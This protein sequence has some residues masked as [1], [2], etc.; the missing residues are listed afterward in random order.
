MKK[1]KFRASAITEKDYCSAPY[2]HRA[3]QASSILPPFGPATNHFTG[4]AQSSPFYSSLSAIDK[5]QDALSS[6]R[7]P[8]AFRRITSGGKVIPGGRLRRPPLANPR[9]QSIRTAPPNGPARRTVFRVP[10]GP[11]A[12]R[13]VALPKTDHP[14]PAE[15][16]PPGDELLP[17]N[18]FLDGVPGE[19]CRSRTSSVKW[20]RAAAAAIVRAAPFRAPGEA[21]CFL[22]SRAAER[23]KGMIVDRGHQ[24]RDKLFDNAF[25]SKFWRSLLALL[26]RLKRIKSSCC[27]SYCKRWITLFAKKEAVIRF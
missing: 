7:P 16:I 18:W 25:R 14:R 22:S 3:S 21:E 17:A 6:P 11:D 23:V 10:H 1:K 5:K 24:K 2:R 27:K 26:W 9:V 19:F 13:R 4:L 8:S 15:K 20:I 12:R